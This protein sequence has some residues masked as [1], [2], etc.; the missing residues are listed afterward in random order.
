MESKFAR[1]LHGLAKNS[2]HGTRNTYRFVPGQDFSER[3]DIKWSNSVQELDR[4]LCKKYGLIS[5]EI[6][7][8]KVVFKKCKLN[9]I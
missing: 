1:Y 7:H 2:Q 5:E 6:E 4:Q 3:S 9:R 8:M